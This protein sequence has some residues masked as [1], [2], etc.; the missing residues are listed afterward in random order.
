MPRQITPWYFGWNIVAVS[1]VFQAVL[2]G[3]IFF[4]YT[5]W[6]GEWREDA[7]LGV[8]LT[9]L[10]IPITI[11]NLAQSFIAPFAG[12]AMDR[13]S[14]RGL[15]CTGGICAG[16]GFAA[17]SQVTAFWQISL[18]YGTLLT[19]GVL[20]AGPLAAQTLA[21]KWFRGRRGFA[22]GLSTVGTSLGGMVM[23]P[24]V[25]LLYQAE[26][27]RTAHL[28]L[29]GVFI[30]VIVP[31]VWLVVRNAPEDWGL[32]PE[33]ESKAHQAGG[34]VRFPT[35]T[36][37]TILK[38]R[39]FW[40][41][42]LAFTPL[43]M[44][45][46][47]I[48]QNLQP[49][50]ADLGIGKLDTAFLVSVFAGVMI[51]GKLFFGGM[52]DRFDHRHLFWLAALALSVTTLLMMT[53]PNYELMIFISALLGFA[54]GGFLPLLGAIVA[55]RFGPA[56]FG[57]VMGLIGPFLAI[58]ALGP[59]AASALRESS[60]NYDLFLTVSVAIMIPSVIAIAFLKPPPGATDPV[61]DPTARA[62]AAGE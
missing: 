11:L 54:A 52:A 8:S 21:A 32:E 44:V 14:I 41:M 4:S 57:S 18:I 30:L 31:M 60:G 7:S 46:G 16:L 6:V 58:N 24:L 50:A 10:M 20:L 5:L 26:G 45:F 33:P 1:L 51:A 29:G 55:S 2:F 23:A 15:V 17:I 28:I 36:T 37:A 9:G 47:S 40:I 22:I 25:T 13:H 39:T 48:Q 49:F 53:E 56:A 19:I 35:W 42:I 34:G 43:V 59:M 62:P 38:E 12:H 3:S 61:S 27:W